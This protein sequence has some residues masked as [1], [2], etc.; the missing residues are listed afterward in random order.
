MKVVVG[1]RVQ[2]KYSDSYV[3][4]IRFMHGDADAYTE[5][6]YTLDEG[7][8]LALKHFMDAYFKLPHNTRCC[9][10]VVIQGLPYYWKIFT[11]AFDEDE[12]LS[13]RFPGEEYWPR[14]H[15]Y[16]DSY[17]SIDRLAFYYYDDDGIKYHVS[18]EKEDGDA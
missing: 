11:S 2:Q 17:A 18:L 16:L 3:A 9:E 4:E 14:D 7:D 15:T 5:E 13:D 12:W 10:H 6:E 1:K 8:V